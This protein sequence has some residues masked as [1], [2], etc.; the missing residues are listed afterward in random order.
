MEETTKR[1]KLCECAPRDGLQGEGPGFIPTADKVKLC[2]ML[3]DAGFPFI[4]AASF[5]HPKWIPQLT[6]GKEVFA[7]IKKK[8]GVTYSAL[9]PNVKA[10]ERAIEAGFKQVFTVCSATESHCKSNLNVTVEQGLKNVAEIA[11]IGIEQNIAVRASIST[12]FGCPFEGFV[13]PEKVLS[14]AQAMEGFGVQEVVLSDTTGMSN[15]TLT[16]RV[17]KM[18]INALHTAGVAVHL[19]QC[20]GIEMA[21]IDAAFLA[22]VRVFDGAVGGL[23]GCPY[24][25]NSFGNVRTETLIEMFERMGIQTGVDKAAAAAAGVFANELCQRA[26]KD[27]T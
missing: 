8:E 12:S 4:E 17:C 18:V 24:A 11:K 26:R 7:A 10:M 23:G 6:D 20:G 3:T 9:V 15:P 21:N 1:V 27:R 2:D 13:E 5:S 19:H 14:I 22:G 16:Y 25:P